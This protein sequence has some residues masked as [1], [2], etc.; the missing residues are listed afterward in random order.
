MNA[1]LSLSLG[2]LQTTHATALEAFEDIV[3]GRDIRV[4]GFGEAHDLSEG[5]MSG[6]PTTLSRFTPLLPS[7]IQRQGVRYLGVEMFSEEESESFQNYLRTNDLDELGTF[8]SRSSPQGR[9]DYFRFFSDIH[10][11]HASGQLKEFACLGPSEGM[12]LSLMFGGGEDCIDR[13]NANALKWAERANKEGV[14]IA[15]YNGADHTRFEG[16]PA[17]GYE[18][19]CYVPSLLERLNMGIEHYLAVRLVV[20]EVVLH[21]VFKEYLPEYYELG[22]RAPLLGVHLRKDSDQGYTI[23]YSRVSSDWDGDGL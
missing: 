16:I 11:F 8:F 5:L 18:R 17:G 22:Q 6:L 7:L 2:L 9:R 20:P 12:V 1:P 3:A 10:R 13:I 19:A 15:F 21:P 23:V 4:F 14:K